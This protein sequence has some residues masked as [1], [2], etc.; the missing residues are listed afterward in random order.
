VSRAF[1]ALA[2]WG[3]VNVDN[4]EIEIVDA[5]GLRACTRSTRRSADEPVRRA[6]PLRALAA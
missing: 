6:E 1:S 3:L 5:T 2:E 4:R